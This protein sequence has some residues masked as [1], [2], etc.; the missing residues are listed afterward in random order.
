MTKSKVVERI[1][2]AQEKSKGSAINEETTTLKGKATKLTA[3][4]GKGKGKRPTSARKTITQDPNILSWAR[5]FCRVVHIF[6]A[7]T[8]STDLGESGIVVLPKVTSGTD[9]HIQSTTSGTEAQ[10]DG[11]TP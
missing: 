7:D 3:T 5:G 8:H 9:A 6:L 11:E 4:I 10:T 1:K 2:P